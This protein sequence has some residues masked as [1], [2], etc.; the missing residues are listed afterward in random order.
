MSCNEVDGPKLLNLQ[1]SPGRAKIKRHALESH[2]AMAETV[3]MAVAATVRPGQVVNEKDGSVAGREELL[4]GKDLTPVTKGILGEQAKLRQ[5]VE[6]DARRLYPFDFVLD[7]LDR[8]AE[9]DLP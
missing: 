8:A 2:D 4:E 7:Q 6:H 3:K 9:L 1:P 5:A